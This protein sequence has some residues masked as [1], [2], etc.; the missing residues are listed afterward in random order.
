MTLT[1]DFQGQ[2]T[3]SRSLW[4]YHHVV[5]PLGWLVRP[6]GLPGV[7]SLWASLRPRCEVDVDEPLV[8]GTAGG[9]AGRQ[10]SPGLPVEWQV[11]RVGGGGETRVVVAREEF[12]PGRA[13]AQNS[14]RATT[15]LVSPP[16]PLYWLVIQRV[17][18]GNLADQLRLLQFPQP[19][20]HQ[21]RPHTEDAVTPTNSLH[22][23]DRPASLANPTG[24]RRG[25]SVIMTL[26]SRGVSAGQ[27]RQPNNTVGAAAVHPEDEL[28]T[29]R[30]THE[31]I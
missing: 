3:L 14:S 27:K 16:P 6:A 28:P 12:C 19:G 24:T 18:R 21:H 17:N 15:T 30:W 10:G 23:G 5:C 22:Q 7:G 9:G 26:F 31:K 11:S 2:M 1:L 29:E 8:E 13:Q 25:D 4:R 20:A